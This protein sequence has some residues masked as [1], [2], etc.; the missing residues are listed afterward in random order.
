MR[1][2]RYSARGEAQP[3]LPHLGPPLAA[4]A[5]RVPHP[6][7][8][9]SLLSRLLVLWL[10][11]LLRLGNTRPLRPEDVWPL[12]AHLRCEAA[13][14]LLH[15]HWIASG[16]LSFAFLRAFGWRY[17][18]VGLLLAAAYACD[19][20]GPLVLYH[21][22]V[23]VGRASPDLPQLAQWLALLLATRVLRALL[24]AFVSAESQVVALQFASALQSIV[25]QKALRLSA[26]ARARKS[27]AEVVR[28]YAFDV[29][30]I[31]RAAYFL[32]EAW[33]LPL[34]LAAA[35]A[36]L[37]AVVS[38][39]ALAGF[40]AAVAVLLLQHAL[41]RAQTRAFAS[42]ARFTDARFQVVRELFAAVQ[43]VK[44]HAWERQARIS[45]R[46]VVEFIDLGEV[47]PYAVAG[48][49]A[50]DFAAK[51]EPH[52][53]AVAVE[54]V[55]CGW[56]AAAPPLFHALSL[57]VAR[58]ALVVVH[59]APGAGNL[60]ARL[61]LARA[62][63]SDADVFVLDAPLATVDADFVDSAIRVGAGGV[64][65]HTRN[66]E[67]AE[68]ADPP[69]SPLVAS[70]GAGSDRQF[71]GAFAGA[72]Y[73]RHSGQRCRSG[74]SG[75]PLPLPS[76]LEPCSTET[77][78][79]EGAESPLTLVQESNEV[80]DDRDE[81]PGTEGR[82]VLARQGFMIYVRAVGGLRVAGFLVGVQCTWQLLQGGYLE[83]FA[84]ATAAVET[85]TTA[86][87][88]EEEEGDRAKQQKK[89]R[90]GT[91]A[92]PALPATVAARPQ[93]EHAS[94]SA[95]AQKQPADDHEQGPSGREGEDV[96]DTSNQAEAI[97]GEEHAGDYEEEEEEEEE[98][99]PL[100][101]FRRLSSLSN[102]E[103]EGER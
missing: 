62:C 59:G 53:V 26:E 57:S 41:A 17:V 34:A 61:A 49:D 29:Q 83:R 79:T 25:F 90:S 37:L 35:L 9:A 80:E 99:D 19:L 28:L 77:A 33:V 1:A 15:R 13:A 20:A 82:A 2:T 71:G 10:E 32:H 51:Y 84:G 14:N 100:Q 92:P 48:R 47:D 46:R 52:G 95:S 3:L 87:E 76:V 102:G 103:P 30:H 73:S 22:V 27:T 6:Q 63:Y 56:G 16:S 97:E 86:E 24:F 45:A 70:G 42:L 55:T 69:V 93:D 68:L 18:P 66:A 67:R 36:L 96:P 89:N 85:T 78:A 7:E 88:E 50:L 94:V 40:A 74:S 5:S 75:R 65:T 60:T 31:L 98:E 72:R 43:T 64:L 38:Y 12:A 91:S 39:A 101:F 58:G 54:G 44:L 21:V 23:L 11:P 8:R 4:A 81:A